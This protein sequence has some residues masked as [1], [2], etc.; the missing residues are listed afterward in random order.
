LYLKYSCNFSCLAFC[1]ADFAAGKTEEAAK[2]L[3]PNLFSCE[4]VVQARG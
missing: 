3:S 1:S 2:C 4:L